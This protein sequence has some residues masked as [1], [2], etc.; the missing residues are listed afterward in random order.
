MERD[1]V[2][3]GVDGCAGAGKSTFA[4]RLA[5][6]L[7]R[8]AVITLDDFYRPMP[9]GLGVRSPE[10]GLAATFEWPRL[11]E[12]ALTPLA[13]GQ[14]AVYRRRDWLTDRL[15]PEPVRVAASG[16][17]VVEGVF[18]LWPALRPFYAVRVAVAA[19]AALRRARIVARP[20]PDLGWLEDWLAV[21][22]WYMATMDPF[23]VADVVV[24]G[25]AERRNEK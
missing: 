17:I 18:A 1:P 7:P 25:E 15:L 23:A 10:A 12:E 21:E 11:L 3:V 5:A 2:L 6:A 22:T 19:G 8:A 9:R 16:V 13:A 20:Q 4:R 24:S 14:A